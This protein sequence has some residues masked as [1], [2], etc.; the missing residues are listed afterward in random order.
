M[1]RISGEKLICFPSFK[2]NPLS[3]RPVIADLKLKPCRPKLGWID[4][5]HRE[6]QKKNSR[7]TVFPAFLKPYTPKQS[8][9]APAIPPSYFRLKKIQFFSILGPKLKGY[10]SFYFFARD[11]QGPNN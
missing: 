7:G 6:N 11:L 3:F 5:F 4:S 2:K 10:N 9:N 1:G 8:R